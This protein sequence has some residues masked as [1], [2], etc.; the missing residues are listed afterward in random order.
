MA[1]HILSWIKNDSIGGRVYTPTD[2][3]EREVCTHGHLS[4][5]QQVKPGNSSGAP[6]FH[7]KG[8]VFRNVF[9]NEIQTY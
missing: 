5:T 9:R 6:G 7:L 3:N 2:V 4:L 1:A 8:Q